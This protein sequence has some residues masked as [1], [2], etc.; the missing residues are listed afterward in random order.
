MVSIAEN[1]KFARRR[2]S[3]A[4]F[5]LLELLV[6]LAVAAIILGIGAPSFRDF[7]RNSRLTGVAN[8]LLAGMQL[9]RTEAVKR[10]T[11]VSICASA[12]VPTPTCTTQPDFSG[13]IV[14]EDPTGSC[15]PA[16]GT[17]PIRT[18]LEIS[19]DEATSISARGTDICVSFA[20]SGYMSPATGIPTADYILVCDGRGIIQSSGATQTTARLVTLSSTGRVSVSRDPATVPATGWRRRATR[21]ASSGTGPHHMCVP[22]SSC[23]ATWQTRTR[24]PRPSSRLTRTI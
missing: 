14:F 16:S 20:A 7:Q 12:N 5:T 4:G 11:I 1:K 17:F 6:A 24:L 23:P 18:G 3:Q 22:R 21:A 19:P 15:V 10:Q 9:A 13:W 2:V 8:D